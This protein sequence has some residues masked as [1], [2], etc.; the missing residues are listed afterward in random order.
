MIAG[1]LI[2]W[3]VLTAA[4]VSLDARAVRC[5]LAGHC[6]EHAQASLMIQARRLGTA[7]LAAAIVAADLLAPYRTLIAAFLSATTDRA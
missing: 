5:V 7:G 6:G 1:S 4:A 3:G 2:V